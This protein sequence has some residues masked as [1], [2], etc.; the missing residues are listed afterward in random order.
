MLLKV[1]TFPK[2]KGNSNLLLNSYFFYVHIILFC[3]R[4]WAI[5]SYILYDQYFLLIDNCP[6]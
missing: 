5:V 1:N 2:S 4:A 6:M 3:L